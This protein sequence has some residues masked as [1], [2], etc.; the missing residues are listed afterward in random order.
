MSHTGNLTSS[1]SYTYKGKKK[2]VKLTLII[3]LFKL[4]YCKILWF[5]CVISIKSFKIFYI[6][7]YWDFEI[8]SIFYTYNTS[9]FGLPTFQVLSSHRWLVAT[10]LD[11]TALNFKVQGAS[12]YGR[13]KRSANILSKSNYK[14]DKIF[15]NNYFSALEKAKNWEVFIHE[16]LL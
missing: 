12:G 9:Q 3:C 1:S 2:L 15:K 5:Q 14:L 4:V 7:L 11:S 16:K 13:V 10:V 6:Y 8:C